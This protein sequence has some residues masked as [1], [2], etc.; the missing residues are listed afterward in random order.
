MTKTYTFSDP[1]GHKEVSITVTRIGTELNVEW[2]GDEPSH[3]AKEEAKRRFKDEFGEE[4]Q[5]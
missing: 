5:P 1:K 2:S 4:S 3:E